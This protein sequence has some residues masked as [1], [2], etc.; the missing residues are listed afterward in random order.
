MAKRYSDKKFGKK[1][2]FLDGDITKGFTVE[3]WINGNKIRPGKWH[4]VAF[5]VRNI[6]GR[7]KGG[8]K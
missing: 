2:M 6:P 3:L 7:R 5:T 4:H 8:K 1:S